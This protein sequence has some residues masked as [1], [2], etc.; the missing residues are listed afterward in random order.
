MGYLAGST[1]EQRKAQQKKPKALPS[2][3]DRYTSGSTDTTRNPGGMRLAT[4]EDDPPAMAWAKMQ[5]DVS[6][7]PLEDFSAVG[8]EDQGVIKQ[9][10]AITRLL[11]QRAQGVGLESTAEAARRRQQ[12]VSGLTS[13]AKTRS[14]EGVYNP[15]F[16]RTAERAIS[17]KPIAYRAEQAQAELAEKQQ[18][19]ALGADFEKDLS[20]ANM[21]YQSTRQSFE[22]AKNEYAAT[23]REIEA[24][25]T[26][27][28]LGEM[29][30]QA[31]AQLQERGIRQQEM[32]QAAQLAFEQAEQKRQ[33]AFDDFMMGLNIVGSVGRTLVGGLG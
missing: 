6:G 30:A 29:D 23:M 3:I 15:N 28:E 31:M 10:S 26:A 13:F 16:A 19:A 18:T 11:A 20:A 33:G 9:Q 14:R 22:A 21:E 5:A 2:A 4:P 32:A 17:Q 27:T 12:D 1:P 8:A 7:R 25:R 24:A